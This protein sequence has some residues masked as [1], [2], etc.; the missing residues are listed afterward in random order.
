MKMIPLHQKLERRQCQGE[1]RNVRG[2]RKKELRMWYA[3][4]PIPIFILI[5]KYTF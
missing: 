3:K 4:L 2:K 5:N 1:G